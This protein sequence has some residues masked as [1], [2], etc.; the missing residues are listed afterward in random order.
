MTDRVKRL[1][2]V[3]PSAA[4]F[5]VSIPVT[6]DW[7]EVLTSGP[8]V[9]PGR[10]DPDAKQLPARAIGLT[11]VA[12]DSAAR[13]LPLSIDITPIYRPRTTAT[14]SVK[15]SP[16]A[17]VTLAAVDEG[18]LALTDFKTPDPLAHFFGKRALGVGI[19]DEWARLLAPA[20]AA[21]TVL[22]AG[23]GG[24]YQHPGQP[25]PAADRVAVRRAGAGGTGR[26]SAIPAGAAGF[27][28]DA[29][30]DGGGLGR[31]EDRQP[32]K[33]IV[34]RDPVIVEPL[35]PRFLAPGDQARVAVMLQN[36]ELPSGNF[37]V[38]VA[39]SGS[40]SVAGGD[41]APLTLAAQQRELVPVALTASGAGLG[42]L[43]VD[44]DGPNGF[45]V[46]HTATISV[47]SARGAVAQVTP[48]TLAPGASETLRPDVSAFIPG[49]WAASSSFGLGV[50]YDPAAMV[51]ALEAYP[52][53]CL[54][55]L[56]SRGLPLAMLSGPA[57]GENRSARLQ[58]VVEA[59]ADRQ[60]Y[61]GAFGLWSSN[62]DAQPWLTAY[63]T[64]VLLRARQAGAPVPQPMLDQ[65][66]GWLAN[67]VAT[68]PSDPS[69]Y[70][71]QAYA[72]DVLSLAGKAPAGAIRVAAQGLGSEPTPLAR[73]QIAAS[74]V[75]LGLDD[76]ARTIFTQVLT[77]PSRR[78]WGTDYGSALRDQL[79]TAVLVSD[80]GVMPQRLPAIRAALP[81]ADLNP[82][83]LNTQEQAWAGAA[84]GAMEANVGPVTVMADG[85]TL[86]PAPSVTLPVA[87]AVTVQNPGK[88][89]LRGSLVVQGVPVTPPTA[90][91]S[92]MSV[93]RNFYALDGS[94]VD[95]DKLPQNTTFVM[96]ID[97]AATDGQDHR[98]VVLAG[99]PAGWEIAGRFT[100]GKVPGMDWL[101][102]LS[103]TESQAAADDRYAAVVGLTADEPSFR[104]AVILRA[105]TPGSYEYPGI[106][107]ADMYRPA[108]FARQN[109]VRIS[110]TPAAP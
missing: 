29:T 7:V 35:L 108:V 55:Q 97:G 25:D 75:R 77:D 10:D 61:D 93:R 70:A 60:R 50:R 45:H 52:L 34:M 96:V 94:T 13:T 9:P 2:N 23:R 51:R 15:T 80:S 66:L 8:C 92:G 87:G 59:L 30:A 99:L 38:H 58:Q 46:K 98:A 57:A 16:G 43:T 91:R 71:A 17:W 110:V 100:S 49:T 41:P 73:A 6:A 102:E 19:H 12:L 68:P 79:A 4:S 103:E 1:I 104:L 24:R 67:E 85:K 72:L 20:G 44:A 95:P 62:G 36:L 101:G 90:A 22:R 47:H 76:Q 109:T 48:V 78:A 63:A 83:A 56:A 31:S 107:E 42:T 37:R 53:D 26:A 106:T 69:D 21:N 27:R 18:I 11:W 89:A 40:L 64:D 65:A 28:R 5:D 86:G 105:V 14:L 82:D 88:M 3:T 32:G 33:D 81:G 84:A 39:A 54:E 74:L